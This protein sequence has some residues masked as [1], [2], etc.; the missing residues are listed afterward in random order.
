MRKESLGFAPRLMLAVFGLG[1]GGIALGQTI[2]EFAV[3]T[4]K[5]S[6]Y[7]IVTGPDGALWFTEYLGNK[8]GR[9]TTAGEVEEFAIPTTDG[10]AW[11]I[12]AGP[13]GAL[14]LRNST[15][16]RLAGLPRTA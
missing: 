5:G 11:G 14:W 12:T 7:V 8:I 15:P 6:P 13:D 2:N 9:I 10:G 3:P 16:I 1:L 4:D